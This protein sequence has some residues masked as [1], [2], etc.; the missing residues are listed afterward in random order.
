MRSASPA[1]HFF[2]LC[3]G[4]SGASAGVA[5]RQREQ[6]PPLLHAGFT[7]T[8]PVL[9]VG[10][11]VDTRARFRQPPVSHGIF[12]RSCLSIHGPCPTGRD[13]EAAEPTAAQSAGEREPRASN[14]RPVQHLNFEIVR[15]PRR[16]LN[17]SHQHSL[18]RRRGRAVHRRLFFPARCP[19]LVF[20]PAP[21]GAIVVCHALSP[22]ALG[23]L[24]RAPD[25]G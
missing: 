8:F 14:G 19:V 2:H 20:G 15:L 6:P 12:E 11:L 10:C 9:V 13:G 16:L 23:E 7:Q 17:T 21:Q 25:S 18:Q 24:I 4:E 22:C 5:L 1:R 3:G